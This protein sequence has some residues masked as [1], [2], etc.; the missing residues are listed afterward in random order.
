MVGR[1]YVRAFV[2]TCVPTVFLKEKKVLV[3]LKLNMTYLNTIN[4]DSN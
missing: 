3:L 4:L 2:G 1:V